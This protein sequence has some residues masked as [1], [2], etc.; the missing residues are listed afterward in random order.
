MPA[1][2]LSRVTG[3]RRSPGEDNDAQL[4]AQTRTLRIRQSHG[5]DFSNESSTSPLR[6]VAILA[7]NNFHK[8]ARAA[9]PK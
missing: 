7:L 9:G 6:A 4:F 8:L 1:V 3:Y 2:T 5:L